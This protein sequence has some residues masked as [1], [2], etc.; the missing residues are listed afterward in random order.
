MGALTSTVSDDSQFNL[1]LVCIE[2]FCSSPR[3][4]V[5]QLDVVAANLDI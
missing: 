3:D 1:M 5:R 4:H 2:D